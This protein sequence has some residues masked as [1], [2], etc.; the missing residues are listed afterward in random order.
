[1]DGLLKG[2]EQEIKERFVSNSKMGPMRLESDPQIFV[3]FEILKE[4]KGKLVQE[5]ESI[6]LPMIANNICARTF[7]WPV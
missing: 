4:I 3:Q 1:M 7:V 2:S 5:H 6:V